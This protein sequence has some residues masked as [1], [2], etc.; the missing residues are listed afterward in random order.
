MQGALVLGRG[1][2]FI[3]ESGPALQLAAKQI[4]DYS[5]YNDDFKL[6][7][8]IPF[9]EVISQEMVLILP[10]PTCTMLT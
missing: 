1:N 10:R 2:S 6:V 5:W 4:S 7:I 9:P 8:T 3:V